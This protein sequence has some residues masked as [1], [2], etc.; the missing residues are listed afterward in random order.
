[1]ISPAQFAQ[2]LLEIAP[3]PNEKESEVG[4]DVTVVDQGKS[5]TGKVASKDSNGR[6]RLSFQGA[7]PARQDYLPT[8]LK[9]EDPDKKLRPTAPQPPVAGKQPPVA[10]RAIGSF[11]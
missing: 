4:D 5:F 2:R 6:L 10:G 9:R 3:E 8:E 11:L 7:R 1:M